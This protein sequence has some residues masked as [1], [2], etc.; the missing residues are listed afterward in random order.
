MPRLKDDR[1][2]E[3]QIRR[4]TANYEVRLLSDNS[5]IAGRA[6]QILEL[7]PHNTISHIVQVWVDKGNGV[8]LSRTES[9][10]KGNTIASSFYTSIS[11]PASIAA[12]DLS[13][14]FPR[15]ASRVKMSL[16]PLFRDIASLRDAARFD[17]YLPTA[18]PAGFELDASEMVLLN[19]ERVACL[20]FSDGITNLTICQNPTKQTPSAYSAI[21]WQPLPRGQA[22]VLRFY[23]RS[24]L[25]IAGPRNV[26]VL[27]W[28]A[29]RVDADRERSLM[30]R[31]SNGS[32]VPLSELVEIR[33]RGM[34]LDA[35]AAL[36]EISAQTR[37]RFDALV[38]LYRDGWTWPRIAEQYR[39]NVQRVSERIRIYR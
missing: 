17:V 36:S 21:L 27:C 26:E 22:M 15:R 29:G 18:M 14:R 2:V 35:L 23:R 8:I 12:S 39:A 3:R 24:V 5:N 28:I 7:H 6:C 31:L 34:M 38:S 30:E 11:F 16:S 1:D 19:G 4:I 32:G 9:D 13:Y 37:R 10:H 33:N 25:M 20:R